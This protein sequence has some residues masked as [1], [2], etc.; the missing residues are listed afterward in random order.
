MMITTIH[1][2]VDDALLEKRV[3]V[4]EN[5]NEIVNWTE[6]WVRDELV[7]RSVDMHLKA[8]LFADAVSAN[9]E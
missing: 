7:H 1:G 4:D 6:Y 8:A 9:F 3:G 5:E 2:L